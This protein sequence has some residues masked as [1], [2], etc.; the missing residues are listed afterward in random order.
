MISTENPNSLPNRIK[1]QTICRAIS[2]LDA[3][4]EQEWEFRYHSYNKEWAD[5]EEFFEMRN[6]SGDH[7]LILFKKEACV[8]NGFAHEFPQ[9]DK[10]K[11]TKDLPTTFDEFIFGEPVSMVGTTFCIWTTDHKNWQIGQ[12]ESHSDHS[13][14]MLN[15]FDGQPQ[16]Y[17][18]WATDYF[19]GSYARGGIPLETVTQ[20][21]NGQTLT[22]EMV[23]T[24]VKE[25]Q[26]WE[27]LESDLIEIGYPYDFE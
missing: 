14:E 20:I 13:S 2:V 4:L 25:L 7:L 8:I 24:I 5:D 10:H 21:Y 22:K 19:E 16:T 17:I 1:L 6:G 3:I 26:D 9:P 23:L 11:L 12:I 15:I 18:N 27:L